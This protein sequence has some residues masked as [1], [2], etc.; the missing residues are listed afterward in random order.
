MITEYQWAFFGAM[1]QFRLA[2][3]VHGVYARGLQG[4]AASGSERND[5]M[6]DTYTGTLKSALKRISQAGKAAL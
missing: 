4:I 6:R 3:I 5:A 2:A 1:N